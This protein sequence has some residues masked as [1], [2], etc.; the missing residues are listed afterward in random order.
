[1][2]TCVPEGGGV[3]GREIEGVWRRLALH[4]AWPLV[5]VD[6][7]S[8]VE[9]DVESRR[10]FRPAGR[11]PNLRCAPAGTRWSWLRIAATRSLDPEPHWEMVLIACVNGTSRTCTRS[12]SRTYTAPASG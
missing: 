4:E 3:K 10:V 6:S 12:R 7:D 9:R 2:T 11:Q 8:V 1:M 5:S